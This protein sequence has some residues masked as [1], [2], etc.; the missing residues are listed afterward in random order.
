MILYL[1]G[2]LGI[3]YL[4]IYIFICIQS[5]S[6]TGTLEHLQRAQTSQEELSPSTIDGHCQSRMHPASPGSCLRSGWETSLGKSLYPHKQQARTT[7]WS[8]LLD[9]QKDDLSRSFILLLLPSEIPLLSQL[10][11]KLRNG[12]QHS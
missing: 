12:K 4:P 11:C 3:F 7:F 9:H 2:I 1:S 8:G 5:T 10:S 6:I